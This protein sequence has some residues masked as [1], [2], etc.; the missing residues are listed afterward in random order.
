[1]STYNIPQFFAGCFI[2]QSLLQSSLE[3]FFNQICLDRIQSEIQS[4]GSVNVTILS[5]NSTRFSPQTLIS[6]L[7][8]ALMV[9]RW[10]ELINYTQYYDQ[11][12]PKLCTYRITSHSSFSYVLVTLLSL[13]GG[14]VVGLKVFVPLIIHQ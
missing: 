13:C 9:Q 14:V 11:C 2:I 1:V 7:I 12:A 6:A 10:N 5:I 4:Q 3:C 8:D